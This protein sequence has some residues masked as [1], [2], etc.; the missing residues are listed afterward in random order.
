MLRIEINN[1]TKTEEIKE[2]YKKSIKDTFWELCLYGLLAIVL[3]SI[4]NN[5][6]N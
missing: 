6:E 4:F 5:Y 1:M 2:F 3:V